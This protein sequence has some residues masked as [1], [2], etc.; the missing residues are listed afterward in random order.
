[1]KQYIEKTIDRV[2]FDGLTGQAVYETIQSTPE[3][4]PMDGIQTFDFSKDKRAPSKA[5]IV[6]IKGG[7][8]TYVTDWMTAPDLRP[9]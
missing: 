2:G 7:K 3:L 5:R 1:M 9:K 6:Q 4:K 8:I